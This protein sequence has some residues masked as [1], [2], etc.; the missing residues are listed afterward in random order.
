[1]VG[2][3]RWERTDEDVGDRPLPGH[4]LEGVLDGASLFQLIEPTGNGNG[5]MSL[6]QRNVRGGYMKSNALEDLDLSILILLGEEALGTLAVRAI[7][8]GKDSD[9]VAVDSILY[10]FKF[11]YQS[12]NHNQRVKNIFQNEDHARR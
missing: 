1:M 10:G 12:K 9:L 4:L 6:T 2:K 8:L 5:N 7:R 11:R 3:D